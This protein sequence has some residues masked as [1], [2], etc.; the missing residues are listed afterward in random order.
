MFG[1][2]PNHLFDTAESLGKIGARMHQ[3]IVPNS[4]PKLKLVEAAEKLFAE[5]GFDVVSV[6]DITQAAGGNVA[7]VNYH[8]GSRDG[9]VAVVMHRYITPVNEA[10]MAR[11]DALE[12]KW[13][14]KT[15]PLEETLQAVVLPLVEQIRQSPLSEMLYCKLIGRIFGMH[16]ALPPEI[17]VQLSVLIN[18]LRQIL[19]RSLPHLSHEEVVWRIHFVIGG[20]IHMLTH[21][22][23]LERVSDGASG[24]PDMDTTVARFLKWAAAG[25]REGEAP[26]PAPI[27][28]PTPVLR[29]EPVKVK[30]VES[31]PVET[32]VEESVPSPA[33]APDIVEFADR[34]AEDQKPSAKRRTKKPEGESPQVFF[35]F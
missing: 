25:L 12:R 3:T 28:A 18:R 20:L 26:A 27:P 34:E 10:R 15:I 24:T 17:E 1:D 9:L 19:G 21:R 30:P 16:G 35:D 11:L 8:F 31:G 2:C 33:P 32:A 14:G 4:G 22:E 13:A 5:K 23:S 6:R 7:A 29:D